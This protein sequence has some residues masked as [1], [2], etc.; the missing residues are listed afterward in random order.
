[1]SLHGKTIIITGV[2]RGLGRAIAL[3]FLRRG[4]F[5]IGT[6]RDEN[7]LRTTD[8]Q[9]RLISRDYELVRMDVTDEKAAIDFFNKK[10][11]VDILINNAGV[12]EI[13][14]FLDTTTESIRRMFEINVFAPIVY[15]REYLRQAIKAGR[16]GYIINI[17][18]N[19][20]LIGIGAMAP[21][22]ATK[23]A[24]LGL[25]RALIQ[26][27]RKNGLRV[28]TYC[29]GPIQTTICGGTEGNLNPSFMKPEV[30]AGQI[31]DLAALPDGVEVQ[32]MRVEPN[33]PDTYETAI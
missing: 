31:A 4:A 19:A 9:L 20:A 33:I 8:R 18:S 26:E 30:L 3:E 5:V 15:S 11:A 17:A 14:P 16:P 24:L 2:S 23:H 10:G 25:G 32:E 28:T 7:A 21:Y 29:P 13:K 22:C 1:M 12:A 27:F 6:G